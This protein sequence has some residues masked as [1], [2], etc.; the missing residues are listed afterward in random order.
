MN[1][2]ALNLVQGELE[3]L[4]DLDEM[5]RLS[6]DVL[7]FDPT[8]VGGTASKGAFARSLVGY[9]LHED[10]LAALVDAIMLTSTEADTG[11]RSALRT[12]ANGEL[13]PGTQVGPL[14]V[15]RKL[16]EG[17]LSIV[18]L[19]EADSGAQAALKVIRPE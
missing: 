10:A 17:G 15:V 7:G 12:M 5:M 2:S 1:N 18:Y 11:L 14:K 4:Y 9:C 8:I 6:A 16:G 19:A 3:R 13:A